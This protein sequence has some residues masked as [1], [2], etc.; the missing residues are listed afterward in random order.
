MPAFVV[1]T[2]TP[3][4]PELLQK[5]SANAAPTIAKFQG[6]FL[7]KGPLEVLHGSA[8]H[9]TQVIIQFPSKALAKNWYESPEYQQL[10]P[11]R[12]KAMNSSFILVA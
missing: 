1:V 10:I 6:E 4:N 7:V 3:Q 5:Y 12:D 9:S 11:E 8:V 2:L